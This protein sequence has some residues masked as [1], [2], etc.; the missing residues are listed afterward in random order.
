MF[1]RA[2]A[3]LVA[4]ALGAVPLVLAAV[5]WRWAAAQ[6]ALAPRNAIL[7]TAAGAALGLLSVYLE[8]LLFEVSGL[9]V[10]ASRVGT[11]AALLTMF[12]FVAPL[13]QGLKVL[14]VWPLYRLRV[15]DGSRLGMLYAACAGAGF[16]A[17]VT[18]H[19]VAAAPHVDLLLAL[20]ALLGAP[21]HL[22]FAG[23]WGFALGSG[24]AGRGRWFSLAFFVA[25]VSHGFYAH[26]VFG[27]GPGLLVAATPL[28]LLMFVTSWAALRDAG[29]VHSSRYALLQS[30]EPPSIDTVR[31][32]LTR[33]NRPLMPHWIAL[34]ALVTLGVMVTLLA[35]AV[36]VGHRVGIDFAVASESDWRST[37]PLTLLGAAVFASF[38]CASFLVARA[39]AATSVLEPALGAGLAIAL[40][41]ALLSMAAP[42]AIVL[43]LAGA[44]VAFGLAVI[45]AWFGLD[46]AT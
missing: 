32:A 3:L 15:L 10:D 34:G 24:R 35:L 43:A 45:G 22:Y 28:V 23:V 9:S 7:T 19:T 20:R 44:P 18:F 39:T 30:F 21:A 33:K 42:V 11:A 16:G 25:M 26:V 6:R 5:L 37:G 17:A 31:R 4:G 29:L 36:Y 1:A 38:P 12:L 46:R 41:F 2:L 14:A 8:A 13:E 27:R 40:L